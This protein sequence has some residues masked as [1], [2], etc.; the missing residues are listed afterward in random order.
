MI[1]FHWKPSTKFA[2][3]KNF[4][5]DIFHNNKNISAYQKELYNKYLSKPE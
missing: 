4:Y 1:K 5:K 2:T 3:D